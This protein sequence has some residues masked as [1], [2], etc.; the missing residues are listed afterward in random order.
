MPTETE[1]ETE[2]KTET[3]EDG[4]NPKPNAVDVQPSNENNA[5]R[6]PTEKNLN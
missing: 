2:T 6:T 5:E 3:T 4:M 1:T